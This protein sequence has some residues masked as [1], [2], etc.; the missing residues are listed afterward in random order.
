MFTSLK[1]YVMNKLK[2]SK[3]K[4][5]MAHAHLKGGTTKLQRIQVLK[6]KSLKTYLLGVK[7]Y[8]HE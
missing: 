2:N 5:L 3:K 7:Y 4:D 6:L 8:E 1:F